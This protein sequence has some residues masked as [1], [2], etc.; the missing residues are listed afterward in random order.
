MR[1]LDVLALDCL[2]RKPHSTHLGLEQSIA[3]AER[4]GAKRTYFIH[5]GHELE[6]EEV[7]AELP[8]GVFLAWDG[9]ELETR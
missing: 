9:L 4:I 7:Q 8:A 2:R 3:Y 6:H 1:G 5:M